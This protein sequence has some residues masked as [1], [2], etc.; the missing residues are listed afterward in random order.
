MHF[1]SSQTTGSETGIAAA[2]AARFAVDSPVHFVLAAAIGSVSWI[3]NGSGT[4]SAAAPDSGAAVALGS[5]S[6]LAVGSGCTAHC[7]AAT[8][9][10]IEPALDFGD[11]IDWAVEFALGI[12]LDFAIDFGT[13][14]YNCT[15]RRLS[16]AFRNIYKNLP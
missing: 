2:F 9:S 8:D 15:L 13:S 14:P 3:E 11:P 5:V 4:V 1:S 16:A 7:P 10:E 6:A 12:E